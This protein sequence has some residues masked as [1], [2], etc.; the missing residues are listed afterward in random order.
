M[1]HTTL[2]DA[3]TLAA[4]LDDADWLVIDTRFDLANPA[5]GE[6]DYAASGHI[7]GAVYAHLDTVL[8]GKGE[9][10]IN[11]GRHPLPSREEAARRFAALGIGDATQVV[12][13]DTMGA[14]FAG[15]LWWMLRWC[16]HE[17]VAVLDGGFAAWQA[18]AATRP[19]ADHLVEKTVVKRPPAPF[20]LRPALEQLVD[21]QAVLA[22]IDSAACTVLD[23][24]APDRFRGENEK[25]DP[26]AG[27]IPGARNGFFKD[28][29]DAD[30]RFR[31]AAALRERFEAL[32]GG[33]PV[34]HQCGSGVTACHNLLAARHAGIASGVLYAG[35]WSEWIEDGARP[36]VTGE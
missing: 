2:I 29:L 14:M 7:R 31:P 22:N 15:R 16:G 25:T 18:Y 27:H 4:H 13:Y 23:A 32:A 30:G 11:G 8:S 20:T 36:V 35:S 28:N 24:R 34:I 17:N 3:A 6:A 10:A 5:W 19:D 1:P 9:A 12:V 26:V 21:A 33:K